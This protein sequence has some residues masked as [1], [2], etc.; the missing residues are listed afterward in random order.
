[1][2]SIPANMSDF[3]NIDEVTDLEPIYHN[4]VSAVELY[5]S[6]QRNSLLIDGNSTLIS[7]YSEA[8]LS[9][10]WV[11][12]CL[13]WEYLPNKSFLYRTDGALAQH[14]YSGVDYSQV[15]SG[16]ITT[17]SDLTSNPTIRR[18]P[19]PPPRELKHAW[20]ESYDSSSDTVREYIEIGS[21]NASSHGIMTE[22]MYGDHDVWRQVQHPQT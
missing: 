21:N 6:S 11:H 8:D 19:P 16:Y 4:I 7:I 22:S 1:M 14:Q 5:P 13:Y 10:P 18:P 9:T 20:T 2:L 17:I 12:P 3:E 15:N